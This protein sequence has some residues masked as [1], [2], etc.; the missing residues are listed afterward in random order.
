MPHDVQHQAVQVGPA[1]T[2]AGSLRQRDPA[3]FSGTDEQDVEYWLT[4]YERLSLYNK[5]DDATN[6]N[7]VIFYITGVANFWYRNHEVDIRTR[8]AFR[9]TFSEVFGRPAV[10]KLR[11]EQRL[12]ERSQQVGGSFTSYIEDVID[13]CKR[14]NLHMS[15]ADKIKHILKGVDD[16]AFQ[17]LV[18]RD[19]RT[20]GEVVTLC[21]SFEELRKQRLLTRQHPR[22]VESLARLTPAPDTSSLLQ[23]IKNFV[24]EEVARQL[25]LLPN[26]T[27]AARAS[28]GD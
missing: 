14:V 25:S 19:L 27:G 18:A 1:V 9:T 22:Q 7:N 8:S 21:Q 12:R 13:L 24:R 28:S 23:Q 3:I 5:W 15:E 2:C 11:A 4:S 17:M 16:D 10:R 26:P 6:L 20:V